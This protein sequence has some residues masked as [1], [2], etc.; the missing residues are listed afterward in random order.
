MLE[1]MYYPGCTLSTTA[2]VMDRYARKAANIL[3]FSLLDIDEWQCCGAMFPMGQDEA[4]SKLSV[5]RALSAARKAGIPL[6]TL[7]AACHHVF[8]QVNY[9]I[10][11]D[12][13]LMETVTNYDGD[14]VYD[15]ST[16]VLHYIEVLRDRIGFDVLKSKVTNPF[17]G[18]KIGAYYGCMLLRPGEVM[19]LDDV[20][21][22]VV[23]EDF[24]EAIGAEPV[25]Y[26]HRNECC[27]SLQ[28]VRNVNKVKLLTS[29]LAKSAEKRGAEVLVTACPLCK[30]NIKE[31]S[32]GVLPVHYFTE[33]LAQALGVE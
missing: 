16:E 30:Y 3:G 2:A 27:G 24:I 8:K 32:G 25:K 18:R 28:A 10:R 21:N 1:F 17:K 31:F 9:Q 7:C 15:G 19:D 22:P 12:G 14:L 23:F 4:A 26:P 5:I 29:T 20:E 13:S 33:L 6:V 11:T